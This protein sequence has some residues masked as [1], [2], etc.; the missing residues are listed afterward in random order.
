MLFLAIIV[1]V[2][3]FEFGS[4]RKSSFFPR[5]SVNGFSVTHNA[6]VKDS[7]LRTAKSIFYYLE[8]AVTNMPFFLG[9]LLS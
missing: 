3:M 1:V 6:F 8:P 7:V 4:Q 5:Q 2:V 9:S